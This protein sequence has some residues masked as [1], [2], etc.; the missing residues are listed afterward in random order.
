M[1]GVYDIFGYFK[2]M[3][4]CFSLCVFVHLKFKNIIY[5]LIK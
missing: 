2:E 5:L 3:L 1:D 4:I